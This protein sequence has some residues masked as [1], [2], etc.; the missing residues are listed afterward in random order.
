MEEEND[1]IKVTE[2]SPRETKKITAYWIWVLGSFA[3]MIILAFIEPA[4]WLCAPLCGQLMVGL[5]IAFMVNDKKKKI[6]RILFYLLFI[7]S[8]LALFI[9]PIL[10]KFVDFTLP[11]ST[12]LWLALVIGVGVIAVPIISYIY[13]CKH[14]TEEVDAV[15]V[16]YISHN[17]S[18]GHIVKTPVYEFSYMGKLYRVSN[19]NF[20][21]YGNPGIDQHVTLLIDPEDPEEFFDKKRGASRIFGSFFIGA[22]F[23][24]VAILGL[25]IVYFHPWG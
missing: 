12:V 18:N 13:S 16:D 6:G 10:M 8:G 24:V 11:E 19:S 5:A 15:V 7:I 3:A 14:Y 23:L 21:N 4:K 1:E 17:S 9:L 22:I 2:M 20:T 25:V